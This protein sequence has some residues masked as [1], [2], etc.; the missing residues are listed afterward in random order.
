MGE[1]DEDDGDVFMTRISNDESA[2]KNQMKL[3]E[4]SNSR[5]MQGLDIST[6]SAGGK[7]H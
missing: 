3:P 6:I 5:G 2:K 4:L 7:S 1:D